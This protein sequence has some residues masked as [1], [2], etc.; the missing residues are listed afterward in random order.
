MRPAKMFMRL[1]RWERSF[2]WVEKGAMKREAVIVAWEKNTLRLVTHAARARLLDHS[3]DSLSPFP[4]W[5]AQLGCRPGVGREDKA[6]CH[7]V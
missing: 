5:I 6:I 7:P 2:A 4:E 3:G 1:S